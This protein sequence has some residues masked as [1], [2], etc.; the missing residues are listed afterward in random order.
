MLVVIRTDYPTNIHTEQGLAH[1]S[2]HQ[3]PR[4]SENQAAER[5][6][7]TAGSGLKK[8]CR[9]NSPSSLQRPFN[10]NTTAM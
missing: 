8:I 9:T 2:S 10:D 5:K 1:K 3:N 6:A 4:E 7:E